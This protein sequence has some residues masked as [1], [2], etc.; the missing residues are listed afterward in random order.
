MKTLII[1][2]YDSFTFNLYQYI[3]DIS[4]FYPW[5]IRHDTYTYE[6]IELLPIDRIIISPGPGHPEHVKDFGVCKRVLQESKLPV[7]GIC[8]GHQGLCMAYGG[9]VVLAPEPM[10]GRISQIKHWNDAL[11]RGIPSSFK[12]VRYHSLMADAKTLPSCLQTIAQTDDGIIMG[13]RHRTRPLFG[14]QYHPESICTEYGKQ[15]LKNF[16]S[17]K[18]NTS[19]KS[20]SKKENE[21]HLEHIKRTFYID[22]SHSYSDPSSTF[23]GRLAKESSSPKITYALSVKT[24]I[25][26]PDPMAFFQKIFTK[27][28]P[29]VWLDSSLMM[30]NISR[31]SIMGCLNGPLSYAL[32]Y[33]VAT[34]T[35]TKK[36]GQDEKQFQMNLFDFLQMEL[37]H[38]AVPVQ[39]YPCQFYCGFVGYFGYEMFQETLPLKARYK[40][41]YPDAQFLFLD[42]A[43]VFD[44]QDNKC[45]LLALHADG[46]ADLADKWLN[47]MY[48]C[49]QHAAELLIPETNS[50]NQSNTADE[51]VNIFGDFNQ[52][53]AEYLNNIQTCLKAIQAGESYEI[54]LTNQFKAQAKI[55]PFTYYCQLRSINPAP[56]AAFMRFEDLSIASAS[57]ER[58]LH[59]DTAGYVETK[60][61]KGTLPRG[62]TVDEDA[63]LKA[64]L[65]QDEQFKAENLMIVD[66]LRNDLGVVCE[67]G[68]V[69]VPKLM[70]VESYQTVHQL[71]STI[72]GKLRPEMTAIDCIKVAFPGGS[73]TGAPKIRTV[74]MIQQL[75]AEARGVYAGSIGYLSLNGAAD[76]NIV[77]RTAI[78]TDHELTIGVGGAIIAL[79][80][81]EQ[82]YAEMLLKAR[83]LRQALGKVQ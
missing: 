47:E 56:Y 1:D 65:Q 51:R 29:A 45:Y 79:S 82:E 64:Q 12:V 13:L 69:H 10:H 36:Q 20:F 15:L 39:D 43:I 54:C 38:F 19:E 22:E 66:L 40:S 18:S 5:V 35:I 33:D 74:D 53:K 14:V 6:E 68:S 23:S 49:L 30:P 71:V 72:C 80:Q 83:S 70:D 46:E 75:E 26:H 60:P 44:H 3:A 81:P 52:T 37:Q 61:I 73:M 34:K 16:L 17:I 62:K 2:N 28:G 27:N 24:Y 57:I 25:G 42:R 59:I 9:Q 76:L 50:S 55:E 7:L 4:G 31:F 58:F 41:P 11:F 67:K 8:L 63:R 48:E 77:I 32:R 21:Y 78:I